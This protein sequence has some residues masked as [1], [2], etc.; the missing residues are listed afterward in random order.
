MPS[1]SDPQV[2]AIGRAVAAGRTS[3]ALEAALRAR[4][5]GLRDAAGWRAGLV[6]AARAD[7]ARGD[8][9]AAGGRQMTQVEADFL[10][11]AARL[12]PVA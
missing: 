7:I 4:I 10:G 6:E 9:V 12:Q 1:E 2:A 8:R 11:L 3:Q 5:P